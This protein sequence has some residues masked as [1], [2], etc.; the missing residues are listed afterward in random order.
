M[1]APTTRR[2]QLANAAI[3]V[4][5]D[6]KGFDWWWDDLDADIRREIKV[7]LGKALE[8]AAVAP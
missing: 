2:G 3:A 8:K 5:S 4:L 7:E 6:R 1:S